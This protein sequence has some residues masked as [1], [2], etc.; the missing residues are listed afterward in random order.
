MLHLYWKD[1]KREREE[2]AKLSKFKCKI[3]IHTFTEVAHSFLL[4]NWLHL[5]WILIPRLCERRP[6]PHC[7]WEFS[8]LIS[9]HFSLSLGLYIHTCHLLSDPHCSRHK[10]SPLYLFLYTH[11]FIHR[12][13]YCWFRN[14]AED[15]G[16]DVH[17]KGW[18]M[19]VSTILFSS[20]LFLTPQ[21]QQ[22][23][24]ASERTVFWKSIFPLNLERKF[25]AYPAY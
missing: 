21:E 9:S 10:A 19:S 11:K 22:S 14:F 17:R 24:F 15:L 4:D 6:V 18:Y 12:K 8:K 7:F 16:E 23:L 20:S 2:N 3:K 5:I 13:A 25:G 1:Q